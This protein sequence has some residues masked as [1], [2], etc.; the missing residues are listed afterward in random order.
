AAPRH[1]DVRRGSAMGVHARV[2][3]SSRVR[4]RRTRAGT[5]A[6]GRTTHPPERPQIA[7]V[8]EPPVDA[9]AARPDWPLWTSI[10]TQWPW[11]VR[12]IRESLS[13][14]DTIPGH[15]LRAIDVTVV[16]ATEGLPAGKP[17]YLV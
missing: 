9:R 12:E 7:A 8:F 2:R 6:G 4:R 3:R 11:A 10:P 16:P 17:L 13:E 14:L 5:A 15:R 1:L